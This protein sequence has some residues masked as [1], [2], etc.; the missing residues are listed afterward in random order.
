[1][2]NKSTNHVPDNSVFITTKPDHAPET[3]TQKDSGNAFDAFHDTGL[4]SA[5]GP[6]TIPMYNDYLFRA[7]LQRNNRV[8]KG[9]ICSFQYHLPADPGRENTPAV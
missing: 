9:M 2:N 7:L 6:V 4:E 3:V 1:M 8:L 5:T